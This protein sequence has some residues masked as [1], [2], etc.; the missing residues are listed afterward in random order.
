MKASS[1]LK[2][3]SSEGFG[4]QSSDEVV[5]TTVRYDSAQRSASVALPAGRMNHRSTSL[6][7]VSNADRG[8]SRVCDVRSFVMEYP[9][10]WTEVTLAERTGAY[11]SAVSLQ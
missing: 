5:N 8:M 2:M 7:S 1:I 9:D 3:C 10:N 6:T 11:D 4:A